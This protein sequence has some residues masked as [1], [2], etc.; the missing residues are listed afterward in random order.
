MKS[1]GVIKAGMKLLGA[2][3][4]LFKRQVTN[5]AIELVTLALRKYSNMCFNLFRAKCA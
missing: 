4:G 3:I 2:H 1:K 5:K